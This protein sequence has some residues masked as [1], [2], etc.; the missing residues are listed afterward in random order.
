MPVCRA[1]Q[2]GQNV[3]FINVTNYDYLNK[4]KKTLNKTII[5]DNDR[6]NGSMTVN[7]QEAYNFKCLERSKDLL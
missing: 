7:M 4:N 1:T 3:V 6:K 5:I 2:F